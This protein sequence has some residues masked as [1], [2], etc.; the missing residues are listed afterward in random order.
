MIQP[1]ELSRIS[2]IVGVRPLQIE[3]D[4]VVSW[5]LWGI[6]KSTFLRQNLIFKG[7]TCI[8]KIHIDDYRYSED[9]DFTL[10]DDSISDDNIYAEFNNI[11]RL[12]SKETRMGLSINEGSK[13]VHPASNSFKFY[14]DYV[15][16]LGGNGDHIK[17]DITRGEKLEF[18]PIDGKIF[19]VYSDLEDT[20]TIKS[21]GLEEVVIEK[22]AALMG[23]TEPRDLYDFDYLT[24]IEQI[25]IQDVYYEF[26]HKAE[27]KGLKPDD[28]VEKVSSKEIIFQKLWDKRLQH[29]IRDLAKFK[30]IWRNL[31]KQFRKVDG[32]R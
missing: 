14:L 21:Y 13:D 25:E 18:E 11:F 6:S 9:M 17:L 28:F 1:K 15:G 23:R 26:E 20:F 29:Q 5:I 16:P 2:N 19:Q 27:H 31:G 3:K 22:M 8:K 30:D 10:N 32:L 24:N 12:I 7:G 4:Y